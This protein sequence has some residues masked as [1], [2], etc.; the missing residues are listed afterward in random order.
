MKKFLVSVIALGA[1]S[2]C[3]GSFDYYE[4]GVRYTQDGDDCVFYSAESGRYFSDEIRS[5]DADKE[6]V[7]K[8]IKCETLYNRDMMGQ[9][10][11]HDRKIVVPAAKKPCGCKKSCKYVKVN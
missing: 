5:L 4:S 11:R 6:I 7:Y 9:M 3:G 2:G 10:P 1:L 8:N